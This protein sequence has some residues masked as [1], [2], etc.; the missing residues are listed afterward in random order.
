MMTSTLVLIYVMLLM[1]LCFPLVHVCDVYLLSL[2][3]IVLVKSFG[4]Q[5]ID[6]RN[7]TNR[8]SVVVWK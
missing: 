4:V 6:T 1:L 8:Y 3:P 2:I 5:K 7:S